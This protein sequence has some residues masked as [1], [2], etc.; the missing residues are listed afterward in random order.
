MS[1]LL[2]KV[3]NVFGSTAPAG[4]I[5]K[6]GSAA[7][8][9]IEASLDPA[10][11]QSLPQY[12][13]GWSA[14][15]VGNKSPTL[16]DMN[17]LHYLF[18][19]QLAYLL[20]QG[21]PE[22][23]P[24]TTYYA[25]SYVSMRGQIYVSNGDNNLNTPPGLPGPWR[26]YRTLNPQV[27]VP[28]AVQ[29]LDV[30]ESTPN[31]PS[32]SG[33]NTTGFKGICW[34]PDDK[35]LLGYGGAG[36]DGGLTISNDLGQTWEDFFIGAKLEDMIWVSPL[37][38]YVGV[39]NNGIWTSA[40]GIN[41]VQRFMAV[42]NEQWDSVC[43]S[44][45]QRKLV[46]VA[47][48]ADGSTTRVITSTN[49]TAW[50]VQAVPAPLQKA[51]FD[52][53]Y[54]DDLGLYIACASADGGSSAI[55]TSPNGVSWTLR[56]VP[57]PAGHWLKL[58]YS[59]EHGMVV[60]VG[61]AGSMFSRDGKVWENGTTSGA[62][63]LVGL[64]YAPELGAFAAVSTTGAD[65]IYFSNDGINFGAASAYPSK[66]WYAL[67]WLPERGRF[68]TAS[69]GAGEHAVATSRYIKKFIC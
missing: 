12:A 11:I 20:Q 33:F 30:W 48:A 21:V 54:V 62:V 14:A 68:I 65:R 15:V 61:S 8:G 47:W 29:G 22:W 41:W 59:S 1:K 23:N 57:N 9:L 35:K 10:A 19:Y 44:D 13:Q 4:K 64:D 60:C 43:W 3:M 52:V 46:A 24:A 63:N 53:I 38:L 51:W 2:R 67:R 42:A 49:A 50:T 69:Y 45:A 37:K 27:S 28:T 39:A 32:S 36:G 55:M 66:P 34:N 5:N 17:A 6:F 56:T 58:A 7:A 31:T 16:E 18:S 26:R 25:G 40:D